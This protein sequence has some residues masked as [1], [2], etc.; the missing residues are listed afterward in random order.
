MDGL[1]PNFQKPVFAQFPIG[2]KKKEKSS[3][4]S[5]T[6]SPSLILVTLLPVWPPWPVFGSSARVSRAQL[7]QGRPLQ[8][9]KWTNEPDKAAGDS[10]LRGHPSQ[11]NAV[12][13][14]M[15]PGSVI[16]FE[17]SVYPV[18]LLVPE[19]MLARKRERF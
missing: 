15:N 2:F 18:A 8:P 4:R 10:R 12:G 16:P 3:I 7:S 9:P 1:T 6:R 17:N 5:R 11:R 13:T 19:D 14:C